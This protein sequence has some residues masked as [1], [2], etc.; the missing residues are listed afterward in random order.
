MTSVP[1]AG[2]AMRMVGD[3]LA[4][5]PDPA[6]DGQVRAAIVTRELGIPCVTALPAAIRSLPQGTI[7]HVD[8]LAGTASPASADIA[9][10]PAAHS[11]RPGRRP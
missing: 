9:G 4:Q 5:L 11:D 10:K 7:L 1:V 2:A 3:V 6:A 8:G